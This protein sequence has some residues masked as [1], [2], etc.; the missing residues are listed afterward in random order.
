MHYNGWF[1]EENVRFSLAQWGA[2]L[3][4]KSLTHWVTPYTIPK[5]STCTVGIILAGNIPL[6][7]F[8]DVLSVLIAGHQVL[9][10]PSS[11]DDRLLPY[12]ISCLIA[13]QPAFKVFYYNNTR[14]AYRF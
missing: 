8:H 10:K 9:I 6:V 14:K 4:K 11:N 13:I 7:G 3:T 12:L 2:A 5:D 1:T